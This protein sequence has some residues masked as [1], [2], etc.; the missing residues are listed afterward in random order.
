MSSTSSIPASVKV[1]LNGSPHL[2]KVSTAKYEDERCWIDG[3]A[4]VDNHA[5]P[6]SS[7][8]EDLNASFDDKAVEF[9]SNVIGNDHSIKEAR[10]FYNDIE[11][12]PINKEENGLQN[13]VGLAR[14]ENK[15]QSSLVHIPIVSTSVSSHCSSGKSEHSKPFFR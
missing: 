14:F 8:F 6:D 2:I 13:N 7:R 12:A 11:Q 1:F 4:S 5:T 9:V 10:T 15:F 3:G